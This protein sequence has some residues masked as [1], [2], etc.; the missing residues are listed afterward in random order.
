MAPMRAFVIKTIFI[1]QF[2]H[3]RHFWIFQSWRRF[4]R[5]KLTLYGSPQWPHDLNMLTSND[6]KAAEAAMALMVFYKCLKSLLALFQ[7][8]INL[9][10]LYDDHLFQDRTNLNPFLFIGCTILEQTYNIFV[11]KNFLNFRPENSKSP[12]QAKLINRQVQMSCI[13]IYISL[14]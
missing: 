8:L 7:L 13:L 5:L 12:D 4:S 11:I 1:E 14:H 2:Y 9:L 3:V 10:V 6:L